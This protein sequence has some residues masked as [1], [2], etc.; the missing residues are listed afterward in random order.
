MAGKKKHK[1]PDW[2]DV[3][4]RVRNFGKRGLTELIRDLYHLSPENKAFFFTRFSIGE[5]PL[6]TYKRTIQNAMNPYLEDG[7]TLDVE[8]GRD[9]IDRFAKA[10]D[11]PHAEAEVRIFYVECGTNFML[12]YG[13][14][15]E[16]LGEDMQEMYHHAIETVLKLPAKKRENLKTRLYEIMASAKGLGWWYYDGLADLYDNAFPDDSPREQ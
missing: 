12:S 15:D 11:N 2:K 1:K 9:A 5:D 16:V 7:E 6:E 10:V 13:Y 14:S 4:K 8:A 3:E